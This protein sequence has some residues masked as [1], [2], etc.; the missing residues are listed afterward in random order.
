MKTVIVQAQQRWEYMALTRKTELALVD[1]LNAAGQAGWELVS[2]VHTRDLKGELCWTALLKRPCA[3]GPPKATPLE[4]TP[5][6]HEASATAAIRPV[7]PPGFDLSGETFD[8]K[9][10]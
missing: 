4:A 3:A 5:A 8:L 7:N 6:K 2:A 1:D 10:D 9:K